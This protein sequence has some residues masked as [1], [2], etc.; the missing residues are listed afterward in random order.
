MSAEHASRSPDKTRLRFW[1]RTYG[2]VAAMEREISARLRERFGCSLGRFDLMAHLFAAPEGLTMSA[3]SDR[4]F[5][6]GGAVTGLVERLAKEGLVLREVDA[7]DRRVY[8]VVLT[9]RGQALFTEMAGEHET[10][11]EALTAGLEPRAL[12]QATATMEA[13]RRRLAEH[14]R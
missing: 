2:A 4:R 12:E 13:W 7:T 6:T 9:A 1:F 10:W 5:I 14:P 3:L 11:V 8:R